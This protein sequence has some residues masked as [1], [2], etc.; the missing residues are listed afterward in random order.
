MSFI[1]VLLLLTQLPGNRGI[2]VPKIPTIL[3]YSEEEPTGFR[4]GASVNKSSAGIVAIKL[5]LD[6][7]QERPLYLPAT[8]I[9]TELKALPKAP[10]E[11]AADFMRAIYEHA[12]E[13]IASA[14]PKAYMDIC[15]KEFVL[16][17]KHL[18]AP[19]TQRP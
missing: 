7:K 11:I 2:A 13:E 3:E 8:H 18:Q 4:W 17:G 10:I 6:P 19:S 5:L 1:N 12:L 16:S 9:R 15:Q 14:V